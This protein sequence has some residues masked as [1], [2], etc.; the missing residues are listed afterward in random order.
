MNDQALDPGVVIGVVGAGAM[1]A[2]IAQVAAQAGHRVLL[3]DAQPG[4]VERA[5]ADTIKSLQALAAKGKVPAELESQIDGFD[6]ANC[7]RYT[8]GGS[9]K[10]R[11]QPQMSR[12]CKADLA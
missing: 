11:R 8:T 6:H 2:G 4:A 5:I 7:N 3:V 9:R 1:G 12:R 10:A